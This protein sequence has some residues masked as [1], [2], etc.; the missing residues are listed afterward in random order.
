MDKGFTDIFAVS[1]FRKI[2][3]AEQRLEQNLAH[4]FGAD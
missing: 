2:F 1:K 4:I 3:G